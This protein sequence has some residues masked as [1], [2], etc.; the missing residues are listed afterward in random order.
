MKAIYIYYNKAI[1]YRLKADFHKTIQ[2]LNICLKTI[3]K[4][5][6]IRNKGLLWE[7]GLVYYEQEEYSKAIDYFEKCIDI[8]EKY[9]LPDIDYVYNSCALAYHKMQ[10][11]I[12]ADEYFLKSIK[13][14]IGDASNSYIAFSFMNLGNS[15]VEQGNLHQGIFYLK[16]ALRIFNTE[17]GTN[18]HKTASCLL[19]I[20]EYYL[21]TDSIQK[22]I[23][24][25]HKSLK[26]KIPGI[27][28]EA[29]IVNMD[30]DIIFP[31]TDILNI[32]RAKSKAFHLR[33]KKNG[34]V[35]DL[36]NEIKTYELLVQLID[37]MRMGYQL[38]QSSYDLSAREKETFIKI[39]QAYIALHRE[40]GDKQHLESA[41]MYSEKIKHA[42]YQAN[43]R[44][45][46]A[47]QQANIP[48]TLTDR[49]RYLEQQIASYQKLIYDERQLQQPDSSKISEWE[50]SL[51]ETYQQQEKFTRNLEESYPVYY[52]M[53]YSS[54]DVDIQQVQMQLSHTEALVDYMLADTV[55]YSFFITPNELHVITSQVD[56]SF[57][58]SLEVYRQQM[59][60]NDFLDY[61]VYKD[62]AYQL[63][64]KL[65]APLEEKHSF[66]KLIVVPDDKLG[67][68]SFDA[69]L[70]EPYEIT[71]MSYKNLPCLIHQYS[72]AYLFGSSMLLDEEK[73]GIKR[74]I[75]A[76][77][78]SYA[79]T[80]Y[81]QL[82]YSTGEAQSVARLTRGKL[83]KDAEASETN[84]K[85]YFDAYSVLHLA[86]HADADSLNSSY[87]RLVFD[88]NDT[89]N[90][91]FLYN[92]E[93]LGM[94]FNA[95][96]LV[97]SARS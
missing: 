26:S 51:F 73:K 60:S 95:D 48:D 30:V 6:Y 45:L 4:N 16:E 27:V 55:L 47:K 7:L 10:N 24:T 11:S 68:V 17:Y 29:N 75:A 85:Q 87:S 37:K 19:K 22:A 28:D 67:Y 50:Q 96:M 92:Y 56:S 33:Y 94:D 3:D 53:K 15:K 46:T 88:Q 5:N 63:Y 69:L 32:F 12:L 18:H 54:V 80:K 39:I 86:M 72:F 9:N 97:L 21:K 71:G 35:S 20:G 66:K 79:D 36:E 38:E 89:V 83:F 77:A 41:F 13:Y 65:I 44:N 49:E 84:F 25:I 70:S 8:S 52:Q 62:A 14:G 23:N 91:G 74:N 1:I 57:F 82:K 90:D 76:F 2:L 34:D 61:H 58:N 31:D 78:P 43:M 40:T 93:V 59:Y 81:A 42:T 64:S